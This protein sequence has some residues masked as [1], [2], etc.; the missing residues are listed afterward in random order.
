MPARDERAEVAQIRD[1]VS[2]LTAAWREQRFEAMTELLH[3]EVI[4]ENPGFN[5]RIE[6]RRACVDSY[7]QFM[8]SATVI[9][10]VEHATTIE[11]WGATAVART[12][13]EMA[14]RHDGQSQRE[15][16]HDVLVLTRDGTRWQVVWRTLVPTAA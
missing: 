12:H 1:V 4:F 13:W 5:G 14:W 8:A 15:D 6:G 10:Y 11:V 7:R 3:E 2:R 9:E 16:G